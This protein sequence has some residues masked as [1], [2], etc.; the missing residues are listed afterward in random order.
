MQFYS[1]LIAALVGLLVITASHYGLDLAEHQ[2]LWTDALVTALTTY[3]VYRVPNKPTTEAQVDKVRE[4]T[5]EAA[6]E[7]RDA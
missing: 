2:Q 5:N 1:K 6:A 4:K 7:I 3:F